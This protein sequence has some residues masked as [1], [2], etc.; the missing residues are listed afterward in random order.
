MQQNLSWFY[1]GQFS[2]N[3]LQKQSINHILGF[4]Q[5]PKQ[6]YW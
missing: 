2:N 3:V 5:N 6:I 4:L 1:I